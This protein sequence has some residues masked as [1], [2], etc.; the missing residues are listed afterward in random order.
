MYICPRC[1][2]SEVESN[3]GLCP[4]CHKEVVKESL[5]RKEQYEQKKSLKVDKP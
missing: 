1:D 5:L 3:I 4:D 2:V